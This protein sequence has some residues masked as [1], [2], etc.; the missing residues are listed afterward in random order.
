MSEKETQI[1]ELIHHY[2]ELSTEE[3]L[4]KM[5]SRE[6]SSKKR[7]KMFL[8]CYKLQKLEHRFIKMVNKCNSFL[9]ENLWITDPP[10]PKELFKDTVSRTY[11]QNRGYAAILLKDPDNAKDVAKTKEVIRKKPVKRPVKR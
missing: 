7:N 2:S 1:P 8:L 11:V 4:K 3:L 10:L 6:I 9:P 5:V